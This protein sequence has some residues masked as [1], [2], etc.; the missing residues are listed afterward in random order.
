MTRVTG[1]TLRA[2]PLPPDVGSI[3]G[4]PGEDGKEAHARKDAS[5][6]PV[7]LAFAGPLPAVG[8]TAGGLTIGGL[9]T[10]GAALVG[11]GAVLL[12]P[13]PAGS[14]HRSD[15]EPALR[16]VMD[17]LVLNDKP[18]DKKNRPTWQRRTLICGL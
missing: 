16:Q 9:V 4:Q 13:T 15:D 6:R 5:A 1:D 10:A 7:K 8:T 14:E 11:A 12:W 2:T 17:T 3:G 18:L